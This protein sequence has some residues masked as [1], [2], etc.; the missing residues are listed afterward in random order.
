M[1]KYVNKSKDS[2]IMPCWRWYKLKNGRAEACAACQSMPKWIFSGILLLFS[3][4]HPAH[5]WM[6]CSRKF[7]QMN[8]LFYSF[9]TRRERNFLFS[10][11]F[12]DTFSHVQNIIIMCRVWYK[13]IGSPVIMNNVYATGSRQSN[14]TN[15]HTNTHHTHSSGTK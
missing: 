8:F 14:G 3:T 11:F 15:T 6:P 9:W 1:R 4:S 10:G 12:S 5:N 7:R 2:A 13:V